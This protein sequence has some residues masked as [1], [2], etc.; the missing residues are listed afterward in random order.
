M[1][2]ILVVDDDE[3]VR[4]I[5]AAALTKAGCE[6]KTAADGADAILMMNSDY[7][8][9]VVCDVVMPAKPTIDTISD[10]KRRLV[11]PEREG[12][13]TIINLKDNFPE[14][15]IIAMSGSM[16][17]RSEEFLAKAKA[18]GAMYAFRKPFSLKAMIAAVYK[19]AGVEMKSIV[20]KSQ[21]D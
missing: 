16:P 20:K 10:L 1:P 11:M 3:N 13:E 18:F 4:I 6:V 5:L 17:D 8:D 2:K 14:A 7:F 21:S 15:K 9:V 19:L 12:L